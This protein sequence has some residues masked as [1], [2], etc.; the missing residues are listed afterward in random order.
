MSMLFE[1][2]GQFIFEVLAYGTGKI[3]A[4]VFIPRLGI[5]PLERQRSAPRWKW[6]GF[7]Y[8]KGDRRFLYTESIQL[9]G[10]VVW[11]FM[12]LVVVVFHWGVASAT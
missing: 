11:I 9:L 5:E 12:A 6:R 1:V 7:S 8:L 10:I 2:I 4:L 3:F